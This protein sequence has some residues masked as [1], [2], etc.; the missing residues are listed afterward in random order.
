MAIQAVPHLADMAPYRVADSIIPGI[1]GVERV[2]HLASNESAVA[3]SPI[4]EG[5]EEARSARPL[6]STPQLILESSSNLLFG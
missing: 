2:I 6:R 4:P 5:A 1:P 3:P